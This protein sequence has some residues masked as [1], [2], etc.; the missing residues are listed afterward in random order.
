MATVRKGSV[1]KRKYQT[2]V[3]L[4]GRKEVE[5]TKEALRMLNSFPSKK[6]KS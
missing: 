2:K 3:P 6:G 4:I 5:L 1:E